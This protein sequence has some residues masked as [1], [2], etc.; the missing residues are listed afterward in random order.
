MPWLKGAW[1]IETPDCRPGQVY[2][3]ECVVSRHPSSK[4]RTNGMPFSVFGTPFSTSH[5][6]RAVILLRSRMGFALG[7]RAIKCL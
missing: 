1:T 6:T 4:S 2:T 5:V 7:T 3:G